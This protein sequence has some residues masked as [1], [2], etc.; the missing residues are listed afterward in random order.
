M[1]EAG[2]INGRKSSLTNLEESELIELCLQRN[3][4]AWIE[5]IRQYQALVIHCLRSTFP[6]A[7]PE[8]IEDL[9]QDVFLK[10]IIGG[11][12]RYNPLKSRFSTY[13]GLITA[14][15]AID[16][17]R[18]K[19]LRG[20]K[21]HLNLSECNPFESLSDEPSDKIFL[22]IGLDSL[23]EEE[24]SLIYL[25]YYE[26]LTMKSIAAIKKVNKST[27]SRKINEILKKLS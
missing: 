24:Y 3:Q 27:I 2:T 9:T 15:C 25:R 1:G 4:D 22:K 6:G 16:Y 14:R 23:T 7:L 5:L 19:T 12:K 8:E 17:L 10:L 18:S 21:E 20:R 13:L 26:K 11:L